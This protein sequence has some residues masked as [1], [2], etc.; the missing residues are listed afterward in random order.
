MKLPKRYNPKTVEEKIY[1]FWEKGGFFRP[2]IIKGKKPFTIIMPPPNAN[3]PLHV[4]HALFITI[5]DIM[6]RY[7]R[8][9]E[10]PTLWL[11]GADHAGILTQVTFERKLVE[12]GKT[13]YNLGRKKFFS[14]I[15]KFTL[16]NKKT[17]ERQVKALG[18][19]CDW[20]RNS[21]T[22]DPKFDKLIY[23]VFQKLYNE[24]L[25][26]R[27]KKMINW[28]PRC[29]TALSDLEVIHKETKSKLWYINYPLKSGKKFITVA[30]TRPE[31]M[32]GDTAVAVNPKDK[33][34]KSLVGKSVILP[35]MDREIPIIADQAVDPEFGTGAVKITPA[36]DPDDFEIS[37]RQKLKTIQVI[38]FDGKMTKEAEKYAGLETREA[39]KKV[40]V[41]LKKLGLLKKEKNYT[42]SVGHCERCKTTIEP[43]VSMQWFI[44]I[45]PLVRPAIKAVKN[46]KIKIIPQ[47]FEKI[48]FN[49]LENIRDW[50]ISRQLWWGHQIPVWYCGSQNLSPLQKQMNKIPKTKGCGKII[51]SIK[52]PKKCPKCGNTNLIQDPDTLDTWFSSGQWPFSTLGW[53]QKTRD[54]QY[55]YPTSVMET[56]YEI[57][58][59]WVARM[60]MLGLYTTG[61]IPFKTVYLHGMVR[62]VFG[63]KM[64]KS[65]PETCIDPTNAVQKYGADALRMALILGNAPG[66]DSSLSE[67]KI[68]G[69]RNFANK[70]WNASRFVLS[71]FS[72]LTSQL[73]P[74]HP[75][76]K[77][78]LKELDKTTKRVTNFIEKYRFDLAAK[79]IYQFFWHKFCDKYIEMSKKR[80]EE[81]LPVLLKVLKTSLILLH[82][83]IPFITEEI[84]QKLPVKGKK[85]LMIEEWPK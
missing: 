69:M 31:T 3:A 78:I 77:W 35:L 51:V 15:M 4:G 16:A 81:A 72:P 36:H 40:L 12:E 84:Y 11:P 19:S 74:Q 2:K 80:K 52:L 46:G 22:L 32:L 66:T 58:F 6:I 43:L 25:I 14:E 42:H 18:A 41:D 57:L 67:N 73:S 29:E 65:R 64:S 54:F 44:R 30:T 33:R 59:F 55:F 48:Y 62:D 82:P 79:E 1:K 50:C 23:T 17:M 75:D 8:M 7:H 9:C 70:I 45:K 38:G 34:Y 27:D 61:K 60:I 85:S 5:E 83:F 37:Q 76:D 39:R 68:K 56:G 63:K 13:K 24:S 53:P 10:E 49:W 28:C 20:T 26:Y 71:N 21:F 47:R